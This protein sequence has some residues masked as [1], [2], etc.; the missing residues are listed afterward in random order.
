MQRRPRAELDRMP[1]KG[2]GERPG[3]ICR[4]PPAISQVWSRRG[5]SPDLCPNSRPRPGSPAGRRSAFAT[6]SVPPRE[7]APRGAL[8][9]TPSAAPDPESAAGRPAHPP[10]H[11]MAK[12][13]SKPVT[14]FPKTLP[15]I[16]LRNNRVVLPGVVLRLNIGRSNT[17]QLIESLWSENKDSRPLIG[18][19]PLKA[20]APSRTKED[21]KK[22]NTPA[23]N[24]AAASQEAE[25][26]SSS[27]LHFM[28]CV[29]RVL[30]ISKVN[31]GPAP[32]A[33]GKPGAASTA[34]PVYSVTVEGAWTLLRRDLRDPGADLCRNAR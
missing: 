3:E 12:N 17:V 18:C 10:P 34:R 11:T 23:Q 2:G 7:A 16:P 8:V 20:N 25:K 33:N 4:G 31:N 6:R 27:E 29:A 32:A 9:T 28:G 22:P 1:W 21:P 24:I 14:D 26:L 13:D 30:A 19:C 5:T 15:I